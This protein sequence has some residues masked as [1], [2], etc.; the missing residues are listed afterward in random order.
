MQPAPPP[1]FDRSLLRR[2]RRRA[3]ADPAF[4]DFLHRLAA[5]EIAYR[6]AAVA[7]GFERAAFVGPAAPAALALLRA[8]G[9]FGRLHV[10]DEV[11]GDWTDAVGDAETLPFAAASLD[12]ILMSLGLELANDL[13]GALI[14]ARR[15]LKP[16]G[17][18]LAVLLGGD[19]LLELRQSWYA[20]ETATRGGVTPRVVPFADLRDLGGLLQRAGFALPVADVDR[21]AVR[22]PDALALMRELKAMGLANPLAER[23]REPVTRSLLARAAADYA[24]RWSDPDG[25]VRATFELVTLTAWAPADSQPRPLKPGGAEARLADALG[26]RERKLPR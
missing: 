6:L 7:R 25:R 18:L 13:P 21:H 2:R 8:S 19:T 12:A 20:A 1:L 15:A 24:A 22:Y 26:A 17:L 14:Q 9:K 4:P 11:E 16:D 23:S 3:L 5:D 10:L